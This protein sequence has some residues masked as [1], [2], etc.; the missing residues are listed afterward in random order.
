MFL[1]KF[2][3]LGHSFISI[4]QMI[5]ELWK[6]LVPKFLF[7]VLLPKFYFY[8]R[9][10]TQRKTFKEIPNSFIRGHFWKIASYDL[11]SRCWVTSRMHIYL[12]VIWPLILFKGCLSILKKYVAPSES[13]LSLISMFCGIMIATVTKILMTSEN[14]VSYILPWCDYDHS[15]DN[16]TLN[17]I[18]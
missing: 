18:Y 7:R 6:N 15:K 9:Y 11:Y 2:H 5:L 13:S 16:L 8:N 10:I 1:R 4:V 14:D 12:K 17:K 3:S